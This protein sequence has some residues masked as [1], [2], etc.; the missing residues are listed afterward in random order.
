MKKTISALLAAVSLA[1]CV[2]DTRTELEQAV[3]PAAAHAK[4]K[5]AKPAKPSFDKNLLLTTI[6]LSFGKT[7][8]GTK[9]KYWKISS[10]N[11]T[12]QVLTG[13][14][15]RITA[16]GEGRTIPYMTTTLRVEFV[17]GLEKGETDDGSYR[18]NQFSKA[19]Q[20][21][22]DNNTGLEI[23][24]EIVEIYDAKENPIK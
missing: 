22:P 16:K 7:V 15:F 13:A 19:A 8:L 4:A 1:S 9:Q 23:T 6:D 21:L 14:K 17:G 12:G 3:K 5:P 10:E 18:L 11:K 20:R 2:E 24:F